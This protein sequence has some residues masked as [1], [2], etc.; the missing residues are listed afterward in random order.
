MERR[1]ATGGHRIENSTNSVQPPL[2]LDYPSPQIDGLR[3][4]IDTDDCYVFAAIAY[5]AGDGWA[6]ELGAAL[7]AVWPR[8]RQGKRPNYFT[9][10]YAAQAVD[11]LGATVEMIAKVEDIA[12][13]SARRRVDRGRR[14]KPRW[15]LI[16]RPA[17]VALQGDAAS[18][19]L[20]VDPTA[21]APHP[22]N[23]TTYA[24]NDSLVPDWDI[25]TT[26]RDALERTYVAI[27][28]G[29]RGDGGV[30]VD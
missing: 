11:R 4:L 13:D 26:E 7:L 21:I 23:P 2:K 28:L 27:R 16:T 17:V 9:D 25:G 8:R 14:S 24:W 29:R 30:E 19:V 5:Y 22:R 1:I 12:V 6:P 20:N 18:A 15:A 3:P 10:S